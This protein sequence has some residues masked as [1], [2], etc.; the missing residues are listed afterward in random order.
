MN[1]RQIHLP[2]RWQ[3]GQ[4][5]VEFSLAIMVFLALLMGIFD[6]GRAIYMYN[7]VSEASRDIARRTSIYPYPG[8]GADNTLGSSLETLAVIDTQRGIVPGMVPLTSADFDCVDISGAPSTNNTCGSGDAQDYVR[9]TVKASYE[10]ITLFGLTGPITLS[11][12]STVA[13]P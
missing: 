2:T 10:P 12:T 1:S 11:S 9:V 13:I 7:G 4:A 8:I 5:M 3:D 6:V